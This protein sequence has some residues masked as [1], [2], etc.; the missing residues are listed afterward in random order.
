M[1][2]GFEFG[3]GFGFGLGEGL[4]LGLGPASGLGQRGLAPAERAAEKIQ[5]M[6]VRRLR[7]KQGRYGK[8]ASQNRS[9]NWLRLAEAG[10]RPE[11]RLVSWWNRLFFDIACCLPPLSLLEPLAGFPTMV[12][13]ALEQELSARVAPLRCARRVSGCRHLARCEDAVAQGAPQRTR[14]SRA[15]QSSAGAAEPTQRLQ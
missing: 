2:F 12:A 13:R 4:G 11:L 6:R 15:A 9:A 8:S 14:A 1:G 10:G 3:F 7:G 5:H